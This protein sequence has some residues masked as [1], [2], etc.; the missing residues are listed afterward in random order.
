MPPA[1]LHSAC[2][3]GTDLS[4]LAS[5]QASSCPFGSQEL[6]VLA[7]LTLRARPALAETVA[8]GLGRRVGLGEENNCAEPTP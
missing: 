6:R 3:P 4:L 5:T 1:S 7:A 8:V 2:R